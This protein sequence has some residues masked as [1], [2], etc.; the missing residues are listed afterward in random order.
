EHA[1]A[2]ARR[3]AAVAL[4]GADPDD[5]ALARLALLIGDRDCADRQRRLLVED[6]AERDAEVVGLPQPA[7]SEPDGEALARARHEPEGRDAASHV[8]GPDAAPRQRA[9]VVARG[10]AGRP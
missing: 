10:L 3:V 1:L 9:E 8:R 4:A 6:R 2:P 5:L 7:G